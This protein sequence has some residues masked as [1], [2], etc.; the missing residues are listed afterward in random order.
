MN[1][2]VQ[3]LP[4]SFSV[5]YLNHGEMTIAAIGDAALARGALVEIVKRKTA[6][7]RDSWPKGILQILIDNGEI[8]TALLAGCR[9]RQFAPNV[10]SRHLDR[11]MRGFV[12]DHEVAS[13][14][15]Q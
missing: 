11:Q 5:I 10:F 12:V 4:L 15:A 9:L 6:N 1:W 13:E 2:A 14:I 3:N 8:R 7:N